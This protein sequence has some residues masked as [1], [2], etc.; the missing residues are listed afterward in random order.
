MSNAP[1]LWNIHQTIELDC[2]PG[3]PRPDTYIKDV[4]ADTGLPIRDT[5]SRWFGNWKWDY[6]DI[7]ADQWNAVQ[8]LLKERIIAL[9]R[10]GCIRY[11][12]W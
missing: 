11:G 5:I 1:T 10:K 7:P 3:T 8:P 6:S 2:A 12:S 9:H 4:L